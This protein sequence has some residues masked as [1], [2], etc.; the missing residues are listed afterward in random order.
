MSNKTVL[1]VDD[2]DDLREIFEMV[3]SQAGYRSLC[4]GSGNEGLR[5]FKEN[6]VDLV[7]SDVKMPDGDG[8]FLLQSIKKL[9]AD[10]P[11]IMMTGYSGSVLA[12]LEESGA[13][14]VLRKPFPMDE[15]LSVIKKNLES[16]H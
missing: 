16:K 7:V 10:Q 6:Q 12:D 15:L 11:V 5:I 3:V 2:D 14:M 1:I 13:E 4:A 9:N 8:K